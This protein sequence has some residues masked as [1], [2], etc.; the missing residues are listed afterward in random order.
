MENKVLKEKE[1][2]IVTVFDLVRGSLE[3]SRRLKTIAVVIR[4]NL[5]GSIPEDNG[6]SETCGYDGAFDR[7]IKD[8]REL[9]DT[10]DSALT[11]LAEV[12]HETGDG[13]NVVEKDINR[14]GHATNR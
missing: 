8:L 5:L 1:A 10:L 12:K 14:G 3:R 4:G 13:S 7:I 11:H 2:R 9:N 6:P